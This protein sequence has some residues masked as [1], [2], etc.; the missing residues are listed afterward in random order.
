VCA[1]P[2]GGAC[3]EDACSICL[4]PG[5]N[6]GPGVC[7]HV[8]NAQTDCAD[9]WLCLGGGGGYE[10]YQPCPQDTGCPQGFECQL[11][12]G[13]GLYCEPHP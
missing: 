6:L 1:A 12:N 8:C 9:G 5:S 4:L 10:C 2:L 11:S 7:S 13:A 3:E